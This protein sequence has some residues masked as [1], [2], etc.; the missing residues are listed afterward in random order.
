MEGQKQL[1]L[2]VDDRDLNRFLLRDM[3]EE[4]YDIVEASNGLE[5]VKCLEGKEKDISIVLLDAVMPEMDGFAVLSEMKKRRWLDHI[6]VVMISAETSPDF[7][8]RGYELGALDY[9]SRPFDSVVVKKRVENTLSLFNQQMML[10]RIVKEQIW[11]KERN[12]AMMLNIL[13]SIVEFRNGESGMHVL[14]I[15]IITEIL[16]EALMERYPKYG[17]NFSELTYISNAA[18]M[19]D[20]GK[21]AVP[22]AIL[23]K[24][25]KLTPEE[26]EVMKTHASE[27]AAMLNRVHIGKNEKIARYAYS[28]CRWHHERWNGGGYPDQLKGQEIPLCAQVVSLADVYDALV[29]VRVYKP[30]YSHEEAVKMILD[31]ACGVFNPDLIDCLNMVSSKL[32]EKIQQQSKSMDALF[33]ADKLFK[34]VLDSKG[35]AFSDKAAFSLEQ[36]RTKYKFLLALSDEILFDFDV[37]SDKMVLSE[38]GC[39]ELGLPAV[40]EQAQEYLSENELLSRKDTKDLARRIAKTT[41]TAP[42]IQANYLISLPGRAPRRYDIILRA[43]WSSGL[44]PK[45]CGCVGKMAAAPLT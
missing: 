29:S 7:L 34:E 33:D 15:R 11:E 40:I 26:F 5:A 27:G 31:G 44:T 22:E 1:V 12:N 18:A 16:L 13:S 32:E 39:R 38:R 35:G 6:P 24:P 3:L 2:I 41:F 43:V 14:R 23:N 21:I 25:G 37:A 8:L 10:R 9:I 30:A 4:N 42:I 19:H 17:L 45:F 36:E 20:V 28:I